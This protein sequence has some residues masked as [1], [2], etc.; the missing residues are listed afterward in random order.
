MYRRHLHVSGF[1]RAHGRLNV[2]HLHQRLGAGALV[3]HD[4]L[5][6]FAEP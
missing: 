3:K 6:N 4:N 5:V 1:V 2:R